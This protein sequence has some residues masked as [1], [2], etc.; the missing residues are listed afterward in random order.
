[1]AYSKQ[2]ENKSDDGET[3]VTKAEAWCIPRAEED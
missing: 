3:F 1:M 2:G